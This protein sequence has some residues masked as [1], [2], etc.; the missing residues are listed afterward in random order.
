MKTRKTTTVT[1]PKPSTLLAALAALT[2]AGTPLLANETAIV[3]G[4]QPIYTGGGYATQA[5]NATQATQAR[6]ATGY[7]SPYSPYS[8]YNP[9]TAGNLQQPYPVNTGLIYTSPVSTTVNPRTTVV[10]S[11]VIYREVS[12]PT[13]YRVNNTLFNTANAGLNT[14]VATQ[15][16]PME[17]LPA[18]TPTAPAV[19]TPR[20]RFP[21][22]TARVGGLNTRVNSSVNTQTEPAVTVPS[23]TYTPATTSTPATTTPTASTTSQTN[24]NTSTTPA[25]TPV[26]TTTTDTPATTQT[27]SEPQTATPVATTTHETSTTDTH[28][29]A[30]EVAETG[31]DTGIF[32]NQA[33][34]TGYAAN[35]SPCP[36]V[37]RHEINNRIANNLRQDSAYRATGLL[38]NSQEPRFFD[39]NYY[40]TAT[41]ELANRAII[42]NQLAQANV[43][44]NAY[45]LSGRDQLIRDGGCY[46]PDPN[47]PYI[48]GP[49]TTGGTAVA[50][51]IN[52]GTT[53]ASTTSIH[54]PPI[55]S[56]PPTVR[57]TNA[58]ELNDEQ[59]AGA[60][61]RGPE[62]IKHYL[63]QAAELRE[64]A[65]GYRERA[66][67]WRKDAA[68]ARANAEASRKKAK[69]AKTDESRQ[70]HEDQAETY[71]DLSDILE[72]SANGLDRAAAN[73][74]AAAESYEAD[75]AQSAA[76]FGQAIA[77]QAQRQAQAAAQAAQAQAAREAE[78]ARVE[79]ERQARLDAILRQS[80]QGSQQSTETQPRQN[81]R[82]RQ[83]Y[84][85]D[86]RVPR[87]GQEPRNETIRKLLD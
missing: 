52:T 6:Q 67:Q 28:Q 65:A 70:F 20:V 74:D 27:H 60:V 48:G 30:T 62:L 18:T 80:Q 32:Q 58:G 35:S 84:R 66:E 25:S 61:E 59:L 22:A 16:E 21:I 76:N 14:R 50:I 29:P 33:Q 81:T 77:E 72:D 41:D 11:P 42:G 38:L 37:N 43:A 49:I 8:P 82:P 36:K 5:R 69:A 45:G 12:Q 64:D 2:L 83:P 57:P 3:T 26:T 31:T 24:N 13:S 4:T 54:T 79:A 71:D 7:V 44:N 55:P 47:K 63:D 86:G 17:T 9:S 87:P 51:G 75:A 34:T 39:Y 85:L 73:D 10:N 46:Y 53:G 15:T 23:T 68:R 40:N 1:R 78:A 56:Y 19:S